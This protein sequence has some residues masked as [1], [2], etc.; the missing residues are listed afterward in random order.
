MLGPWKLVLGDPFGLFRVTKEY[1]H[2]QE[3]L[4]YPSLAELPEYLTPHSGVQGEAR[5]LRQ[6][7]RA[8]T[9]DAASTRPYTSGDPI[10]RVHWPTTARKDEPYIKIFQPEAASSI[11]L[12]PDC[13]ASV[14]LGQGEDSTF[15]TMVLV[16]ASLAARLLNDQ[17]SVGILANSATE[18]V[19]LLQRGQSQLWNILRALAPVE[20][21]SGCSLADTLDHLRQLIGPH[22]ML[23]AITPSLR[24][25]WLPQLI[26]LTGIHS[27]GRSEVILLDPQSFGGSRSAEAM[28]PVLA[29][30][31][32]AGRILRQGQVRP[33][34]ATYGE[35]SR[36]EFTTGATGR[37]ILRKRPR[38]AG[39][40]AS[41]APTPRHCSWREEP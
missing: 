31:G 26:R 41:E 13:D 39:F 7:L 3:I 19:I 11:W 27:R 15:E 28:L 5:P 24:P 20:P 32:I 23:I 12:V 36:W 29:E 22:S 14:H 4:V 33:T 10:R 25:D 40:P 8:D 9:I 30:V 16:T 2:Q 38:S 34:T 21:V 35:L 37:A 6:A 17:M 1:L 18:A